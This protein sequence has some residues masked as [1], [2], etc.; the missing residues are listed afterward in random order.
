MLRIVAPPAEPSD[1]ILLGQVVAAS[2]NETVI[3]TPVGML[4]L[5]RRLGLQPGDTLAFEPLD[6]SPPAAPAAALPPP[7]RTGG[8]PALDLVLGALDAAA[9]AL[10][11]Q[12]RTE[13][14]PATGAQL[15]PALMLLM[16]A[17]YSGAWPGEDVERALTLSGNDRL[18]QRLTMDTEELRQLKDDPVTG[19]WRVL[20]LPLL[21]GSMVQ[22]IRIYTR[23]RKPSQAKA[24]DDGGRF[25]VEIEMSRLGPLQLDGLLRTQRFDL[26]LRSHRPLAQEIRTEAAAIFHRSIAATGIAGDIAFSTTSRFDVMPLA[27]LRSRVTV[28]V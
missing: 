26:V 5:G 27:A 13:L 6:T 11:A 9:P 10:A 25:I 4:V 12:I 14:M 23:R 7:T 15:G 22:P 17:L 16:A 24:P 1:T 8:W 28:N 19:D 2:G 3:D 20:T 21:D 18:R